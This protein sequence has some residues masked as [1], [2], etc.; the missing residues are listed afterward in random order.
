MSYPPPPPQ[1]PAQQSAYPYVHNPLPPGYQ[2]SDIERIRNQRIAYVKRNAY[3][4]M[5]IQLL[6][7]AIIAALLGYYINRQRN[8]SRYDDGW[9]R[10]YIGLLIALLVIDVLCVAYTYWQMVRKVRWLRDPRTLNYAI[11]SGEESFLVLFTNR[12]NTQQNP[13][14]NGYNYGPAQ[15][16]YNYGQ[17]QGG[18]APPAYPPMP[19]QAHQPSDNKGDTYLNTPMR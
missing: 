14:V 5:G 11:A 1:Q 4:S 15:P 16:G 19:P 18:N 13:N 12:W 6:F 17:N 9:F 10:W 7:T 2:Q 8:Y 3:I